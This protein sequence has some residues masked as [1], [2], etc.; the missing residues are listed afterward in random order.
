MDQERES[1]R[2]DRDR[3]RSQRKTPEEKPFCSSGLLIHKWRVCG[4]WPLLRLVRRRDNMTLV[5]VAF[6]FTMLAESHKPLLPWGNVKSPETFFQVDHKLLML[7]Y[8]TKSQRAS[9]AFRKWHGDDNAEWKC[10]PIFS[11]GKDSYDLLVEALT[12]N[13]TKVEGKGRCSCICFPSLI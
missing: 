13:L 10:Q 12:E 8:H 7:F 9:A 6:T 2:R 4:L 3:S 1:R 5:L 11:L